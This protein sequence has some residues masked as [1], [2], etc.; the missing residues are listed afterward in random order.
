MLCC[1]SSVGV[2][3]SIFYLSTSRRNRVNGPD[4]EQIDA[5]FPNNIHEFSFW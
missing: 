5:S 4:S 3:A 2:V 1:Q